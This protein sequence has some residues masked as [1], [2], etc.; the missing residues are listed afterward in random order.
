[1][2]ENNWVFIF[3][4]FFMKILACVIKQPEIEW[5]FLNCLQ[6]FCCIFDFYFVSDFAEINNQSK[7]GGTAKEKIKNSRQ[8]Q[9]K[10]IREFNVGM[11]MWQQQQQQQYYLPSFQ[12]IVQI[13]C[14]EE[15][16][17]GSH[18]HSPVSF[19]LRDGTCAYHFDHIS[20]RLGFSKLISEHK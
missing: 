2:D 9:K 19:K 17:R 3:A 12:S 8:S 18:V 13:K 7:T 15:C 11:Q 10:S 5:T 16:D 4:D 14:K 6:F 1:M 20:V